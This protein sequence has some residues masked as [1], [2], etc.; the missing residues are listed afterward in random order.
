M[1]FRSEIQDLTTPIQHFFCLKL[2]CQILNFAEE[3]L[4]CNFFRALNLIIGFIFLFLALGSNPSIE[5]GSINSSAGDKDPWPLKPK[6]N[7]NVAIIGTYGE[8]R[9]KGHYH[10]ALDIQSSKGEDVINCRDGY[11][12]ECTHL[13]GKRGW[14]M[15]IG[16]P[17][18]LTGCEYAHIEPVRQLKD[19]PLGKYFVK[20]GEIIAHVF[21]YG[22]DGQPWNDHLHY[23]YVRIKKM[24]NLEGR[25]DNLIEGT[26]HPL[27]RLEITPE[28]RKVLLDATPQ[29]VEPVMFIPDEGKKGGFGDDPIY[30]K[31]DILVHSFDRMGRGP[32]LGLYAPAPYEFEWRIVSPEGYEKAGG[33]LKMDGPIPFLRYEYHSNYI[34][35][36]SW[37]GDFQIL[38][39]NG[40]NT[41]GYWF[42]NESRSDPG[43]EARSESDS[44]FKDGEYKI[45][46]TIREHP[47]LGIPQR[48][49][50]TTAKA[51][52][53]NFP[54]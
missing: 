36:E 44:R 13:G 28:I 47:A 8:F 48:E 6:D 46:V 4:T 43:S 7:M 30:G 10:I 3:S 29:L 53:D 22:N 32:G 49:T 33:V 52:V 2:D 11:L 18:T 27:D 38:I 21:D 25:D 20:K 26:E 45:E 1:S 35:N 23:G 24:V 39:T 50:K 9:D 40:M 51:I 12:L 41:N 14:R 37:L 5:A 34:E 19:M 16:D 31:V 54:D 42:T 15:V 17:K